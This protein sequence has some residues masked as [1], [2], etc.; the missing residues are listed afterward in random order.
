M[1]TKLKKDDLLKIETLSDDVR[2]DIAALFADVEERETRISELTKAAADADEIVKRA[3]E[4]EKER[5]ALK[6]E[7]L[8]LE[9]KLADVMGSN[10]NEISLAAFAPFFE[11]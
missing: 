9:T 3:P 1:P 10:S 8:A 11:L 2:A 6:G 4:V 7:K 5:D